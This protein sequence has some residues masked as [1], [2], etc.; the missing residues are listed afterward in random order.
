VQVSKIVQPGGIDPEVVITPGIFV[1][2]IVQI[3][4]V[5]PLAEAGAAG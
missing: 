2:R 4:G 1:D 5:S 3:A